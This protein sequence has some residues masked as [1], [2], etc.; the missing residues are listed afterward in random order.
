MGE[1][2]R[3]RSRREGGEAVSNHVPEITAAWSS[4]GFDPFEDA[5]EDVRR[6][7]A[8][9]WAKR[10]GGGD[11]PIIPL[12][13]PAPLPQGTPVPVEVLRELYE[14]NPDGFW[15]LIRF[16]AEHEPERL[17]YYAELELAEEYRKAQE[18]RRRAALLPPP[19]PGRLTTEDALPQL[20]KVRKTRNGWTAL[21]PAHEDTTPSLS[22]TES[23]VRPGEPIFHCHAGCHWT[24]VLEELRR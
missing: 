5:P 18:R 13:P 15:R 21:C 11:L 14:A 24:R 10:D 4:A 1:T 8:Q 17:D 7:S 9:L 22:I 20:K 2:L 3:L 6:E 23:E 12:P 16:E 19:A